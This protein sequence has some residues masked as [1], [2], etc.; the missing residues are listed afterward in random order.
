MLPKWSRNICSAKKYAFLFF[1]F[2]SHII[3]ITVL[4][5][6]YIEREKERER[7]REREKREKERYICMYV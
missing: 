5:K 4:K 1:I 7:K 3:I 2:K 6:T